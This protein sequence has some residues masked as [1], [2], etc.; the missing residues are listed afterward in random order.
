MRRFTQAFAVLAALAMVATACASG[1]ATGLPAGPTE[2]PTGGLIVTM[3][4]TQL[5]FDPE[6]LSNVKVGDTVTF[7]NN[8]SLPHTVTPEVAT[9]FTG[10]EIMN[11]GDEFKVTF[12]KAG[13][14]E[15]YCKLHSAAG[16]R[17]GMVGTIVVVAAT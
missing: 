4:G 13:T 17:T 16:A 9:D 5:K 8:G 15:Y 3:P 12:S 2:A 1:K 10:S 11:A 14:I 7:D 6:S